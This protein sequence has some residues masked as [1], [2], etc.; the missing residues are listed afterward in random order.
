MLLRNYHKVLSA[1]AE[2][3]CDINI[4]H[5]NILYRE[6]VRKYEF[7]HGKNFMV[8]RMKDLNA[9]AER[10]AMRQPIEPIKFLKSDVEGFPLVLTAFKPYLRNENLQIVKIALSIFRSCELLRLPPHHDISTVLQKPKYDQTV[11][12]DIIRYIPKFV[13]KLSKLQYK[14]MIYHFTVKNGPN[15]P[16]LAT[17]DKDLFAVRQ[18]VNIYRALRTVS[19]KLKDK[20][21]FPDDSYLAEGPGIHSK[22][23]QFSEKAGKT[24]TIAVV[25]YYSQRAL[26][27]LHKALMAILRK[28]P[29]D[30]TFSHRNVGNYA[31]EATKNKIFVATS[32]MTAFTDLFPSILQRELLYT[33]EKDRDLASAFWTLLAERQFTVAWSGD[34]VTYGTGQPM[35][36]YAS[37]PLCT[38]AHHLVMHYCAY[39][40]RIR[41]VHRYYRILGD[42][43]VRTNE[44]L[45]V[46]YEETLRALGCELN[47]SK[48]TLSRAG[49]LY[50]SAEVAKRLYLNGIDISPLTP[51]LLDQYNKPTLINN[52]V[53]ELMLTFNNQALP[54]FVLDHIV[55]KRQRER[56][57]VLCTNPF[58]GSIKP[59]IPGYD[60]HAKEWNDFDTEECH[61]AMVAFRVKSL[62][63]KANEIDRSKDLYFYGLSVDRKPQNRVNPTGGDKG[64]N[65]APQYAQIESEKYIYGLLTKAI[66]KLTYAGVDIEPIENAYILDEVEYLHDM[67]YP[68]MDAKDLR[69]SHATLLAEK[70]YTYLK[71]G[72]SARELLGEIDITPL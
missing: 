62:V 9:I 23:T 59:G 28:L 65:S 20:R 71:A 50:S 63:D 25:D 15:G 56:A 41:G 68:F 67:R 38:L 2:G 1:T 34:L 12:E 61:I 52:V 66:R 46:S 6:L 72:K 3:L 19:E 27:P 26:Y 42:D 49:V 10:Y 40:H 21:G 51:G 14:P 69:V 57:W 54:A 36:A 11:V 30:G 39:K 33:M 53:G 13:R 17:S 32:D 8:K 47:P 43:N 24:R 5:L 58:N 45:S 16:A 35:G 18:D 4:H 48:G 60:E 64:L 31:K 70:V 55:P 22:L 29:S 7:H 44:V 37:W